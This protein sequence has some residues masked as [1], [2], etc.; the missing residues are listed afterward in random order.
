M[1][2]VFPWIASLELFVPVSAVAFVQKTLNKRNTY[3]NLLFLSLQLKLFYPYSL[4]TH[5]LKWFITPPAAPPSL[6]ITLNYTLLEVRPYVVVFFSYSWHK[7]P[8]SPCVKWPICRYEYFKSV[9][10]NNET[11]ENVTRNT[12]VRF[13]VIR[14]PCST[15]V[16]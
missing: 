11:K 1:T 14:L 9:E 15:L 12:H 7:C 2:S 10:K 5:I 3:N 13:A 16:R 6:K 4:I 8:S